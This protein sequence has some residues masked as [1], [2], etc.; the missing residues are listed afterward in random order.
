MS[1]EEVRDFYR[2]MR[3]QTLIDLQI[4]GVVIPYISDYS[5]VDAKSFFKEPTRSAN[6]VIENLNGYATFLTPRLKFSFRLMPIE[7]YRVLMKLIKEYNEFIV[8]AY[9]PVEDKI[10][11]HKMYFYPK[12]F[13]AIY[14]NNLETLAVLDES[15]E[16]VGTNASLDQLSVVY[17]S[18][19]TIPTLSS[20]YSGY[21][22]QEFVVGSYDAGDG[23]IDPMT[24]E[25]EGYSF[26]S[27]NTKADGTGTKY[28]N[29]ATITLSTSMVLYAQWV[30]TNEFV[31]SFDYQGG[32]N[33]TN[34][35]LINKN[36][37]QNQPIGTLP[38][39]TDLI[40]NGYIF[41]GWYQTP[42]PNENSTQITENSY[43]AF[44][45]NITIYAKWT[46]VSASITFKG[47][48]S[49]YGTMA[50]INTKV[51]ET[52]KLPTNKFQRQGYGFVKWNTQ[53]DG[54]GVDYTDEQTFQMPNENLTLYAIWDIAY[55]I[56]FNTNGGTNDGATEITRI[57]KK[58]IPTTKERYYLAGWYKDSNFTTGVQFPL[59][60]EDNI[61]IYA[62]WEMF[63][64]TGR[65]EQ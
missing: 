9:D 55:T 13:P 46:G 3:S 58:P 34:P 30:A 50:T 31:L 24:F 21:Y 6:G 49:G 62:R 54:K 48:G 33:A 51:G 2:K 59:R 52:V 15:F 22:G 40:K 25:R 7:T 23:S 64:I 43:Y 35:D 27:W 29:G 63:Q 61:T 36:V 45:R 56:T 38:S 12:E 39:Q 5:F 4:N 60:L 65:E 42:T 16:L 47:N 14:Q 19:G 20:G 17:N 57:V 10:V 37:I 44:S 53:A 26:D 28:I 41:E 8:S 32:Y 11:T 18:N 1:G